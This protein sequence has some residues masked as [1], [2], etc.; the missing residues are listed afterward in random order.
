MDHPSPL[1]QM[2]PRVHKIPSEGNEESLWQ[3]MKSN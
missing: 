2:E 3:T 1:V